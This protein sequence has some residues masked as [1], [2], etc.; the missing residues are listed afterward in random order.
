MAERRMF[1]KTIIDSDAFLDM[2]L[3]AQALYFHLAMR[4]DDE[5]FINNPK[6]INRMIGGADDDLK[7][8]ALKKFIIPFDTGVVVI[9]HW[10]IHNYIRADRLT[11]TV[12]KEERGML[13]VKENGTYTTCQP[14]DGQVSVTCPSDD[15]QVSVKC[16]SHD[17]QATVKCQHRIG[18]DRIVKDRLG[19][20]REEG[21]PSDDEPLPP[22]DNG[23]ESEKVNPGKGTTLNATERAIVDAYTE[24]CKKLPKIAKI[25]EARKKAIRA[26]LRQYS[27][28][29]LIKV[30]QTAGKS[31]F[32][33]GQNDRGWRADFDWLMKPG[34][35]VKVLEGTYD[36]HVGKNS[37][38]RFHNFDQRNVNYD[39]L[40]AGEFGRKRKKD[41]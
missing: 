11:A 18:E 6:K 23:T 26:A 40:L 34:N 39:E 4:A 35:T 10:R 5:G 3:S 9:K 7:L 36:S 13:T 33:T 38:N 25:T 24:H 32:L 2:P 17:S 16:P 19:Q 30:F 21:G 15:G 27:L 1:A 20:Y 29:E 37:N 31:D 28:D 41:N 14:L 12:Y 8:L 22:P